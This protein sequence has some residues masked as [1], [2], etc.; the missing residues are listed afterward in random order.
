M[1]GIAAPMFLVSGTDL[2][3]A[4]CKADIIVTSVGD[5]T[6]NA[7]LAQDHGLLHF[8][9]ATT[10]RFA[11]KAASAG[12]DGIVCIGARGGGHAGTC[13]TVVPQLEFSALRFLIRAR[14]CGVS[15]Q[16]IIII[17]QRIF[18]VYTAQISLFCAPMGAANANCLPGVPVTEPVFIARLEH[19][20]GHNRS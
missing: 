15:A 8:H 20:R 12:V 10:I 11:E 7:P 9:D 17:F 13:R 3:I 19:R 1:G 14:H 2:V 5:P 18:A 6:V 16:R 4:C